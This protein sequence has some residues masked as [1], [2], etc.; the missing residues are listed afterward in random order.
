MKK[1]MI[2]SPCAKC[3]KNDTCSLMCHAYILWFRK[4]W[5]SVR[6]RVGK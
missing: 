3:D 5:A 1:T 4:I 6:K 2:E